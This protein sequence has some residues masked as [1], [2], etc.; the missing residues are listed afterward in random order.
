MKRLLI[1]CSIALNVLLGQAQNHNVQGD[2]ALQRNDFQEARTWFSEGLAT[3]DPYSIGKL[4]DIWME[5]T[6]MR[7][8]MRLEMRK[9][10]SCLLPQAEAGNYNAM[11]SISDCF[12]YGI[13]TSIDTVRA[14]YWLDKYVRAIGFRTPDGN[15]ADSAAVGMPVNR[16]LGIF[17]LPCSVFVAYAGT[18]TMPIG[19]RAGFFKKA[20]AYIGF[21]TDFIDGSNAYYCNN[22]SVPDIPEIGP[23]YHFDRSRW[24]SMQITAGGI[25][26]ISSKL[27]VT[28]GAGYGERELMWEIVTDTRFDTGRQREWCL[29]LE[30][31]YRGLAFEAGAAWNWKRMIVLAGINTTKLKDADVY[32]GLGFCF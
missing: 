1:I 16:I 25:Y 9:C 27:A 15:L 11:K 3:C 8:R 4:T 10:F 19:F 13:G 5:H 32:F 22:Q 6:D 20:G 2:M 18:A 21:C 30:S 28:I 24:N 7:S 17:P 26:C 12:R 14:N 29:N 31:S 23:L